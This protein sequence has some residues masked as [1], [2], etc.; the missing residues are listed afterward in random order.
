MAIEV[1]H[2]ELYIDGRWV[3]PRK[4]GRYP[5][6][7]P[8]TEE[9]VGTIPSATAED[10]DDAVTAA[11][12]R[13]QCESWRCSTGADRAVYLRAIASK[14]REKKDFLARL[15]TIDSGKP[16]SETNWDMD[17]VADCFD[18]YAGLAEG[19]DKR[20]YERVDVNNADFECCVR[21]EPLGPVAIITPWNYPLLMCAW[22]VAPALA[23]GNTMVLKPSEEASLTPLE[24][25]RIAHEIELPPGVLNVVTGRGPETGA[26]LSA[27]ADLAKIVFTGRVPTGRAVC[28]AAARNGR[29]AVLDLGGKSAMVVFE[30]ADVDRAVEWAMF[31]VFW[32]NGQ[33]CSA[34]SR[35]LVHELIAPQFFQA[36]CRRA[37]SL[38][39]CDPL[40]EECRLGPLASAQQHERVLGFIQRAREEGCTLLTGGGR[41]RLGPDGEHGPGY[42]VEPTVFT[43]VRPEHSL[44][45][46]EV[47]GPVLACA[48]FRTE[49][50]AV[51]LANASEFAL[52]A[53]VISEDLARCR[54]VQERLHV[55]VCWINCSQPCFCQA[56]WGGNKSSGFGRQLG[57]WG[58]ENF[59]SVKQVTRYVKDARW[60]WYPDP[61]MQSA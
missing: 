7:N 59:C 16:I 56:P 50:E 8:A 26:P 25:A 20:Q 42:F 53:A 23:A 57:V 39:I 28:A 24:L 47:F 48:T 61:G 35:C 37:R 12:R 60:D 51:Q 30:D 41:P 4:G 9:Q 45:R 44:W 2:R 55:G 40:R 31:G 17:D 46:G 22:K 13:F 32:T 33:I 6:I 3:A 19:L 58:L 52:A 5:V 1:P 11:T 34:T 54:R 10:I 18:Y 27:H 14:V 15:E 43:D 49:E 21:H 36:L 38:V 29:P